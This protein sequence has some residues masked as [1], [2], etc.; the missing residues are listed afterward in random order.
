MAD[1]NNYNLDSE[2]GELTGPIAAWHMATLQRSAT[3]VWSLRARAAKARIFRFRAF[4][5]AY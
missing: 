4:F 1:A 5:L 2:F 3:T